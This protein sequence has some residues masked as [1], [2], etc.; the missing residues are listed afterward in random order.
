MATPAIQLLIENYP[1]ASLTLVCKAPI[2]DVFKKL[3]NLERVIIDDTKNGGNRIFKAIRLIK[4]IR[5]NKYDLGI[6]FR[7]SLAN[8]IIFRFCRIRNLVGYKNDLRGILLDNSFKLDRTI[9]YINRF[10]GLVNNYFN[11]KFKKLPA[12]HIWNEGELK[13]WDFE[14]ELPVIAMSLGNDAQKNRAYP[15]DLSW[16]LIQQ[17]VSSRQYNL[18]FVGDTKDAERNDE[19]E[20]KLSLADKKYVRNYSGRTD[21]GTHINLIKAADALIT[22][23]SSGM[24]IAAACKIPFIVLLG[25]STSPFCTVQPKVDF[26]RY[27]KNENNL[28]ND[29]DFISQISP[30]IIVQELSLTVPQKIEVSP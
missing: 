15:K 20:S 1:E 29:D 26:G 4:E 5:K 2:Q 12:L 25:R 14:N 13:N 8:A 30:A 3:P 19:Y 11:N 17:L 16:D 24:H 7:N 18:V 6:L 28:I 10:A 22:V 27:I 21:V 9:H 23:D